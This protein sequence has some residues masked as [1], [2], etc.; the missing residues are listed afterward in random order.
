MPL[1]TTTIGSYPKPDFVPIPDWFQA[2]SG[3]D[4][5]NPTKSYLAALA[6]MGQE[7]EALFS[8]GVQQ[9]IDDQLEA[10]IDIP[11][12]GEIR[13]ENYIHYHCRHLEGI[14]FERLTEKALRAGAYSAELPT[15]TGPVKARAPFLP[16]DWKSAQACSDRPVKV[17]LPGPMTIVD[18]T[19]NTYYD[20]EEK[21][22]ADLADAINAEV[23]ALAEAGCTWIQVDEPVFARKAE[24]ALAYG[25]E[26][27]NRCFHAV[28]K[29][30]TRVM[31]MCCGY[32]D[33]LDRDDYPKADPES[34]F[35]LAEAVDRAGI[36]A[37]SLED[38]HRP[39]DLTL[40]ERFPSITVILGVVTIAKS[41][42]ETVEEIRAR[43]KAA[44]GHIDAERLIAAPDC[45]LGMLGRDLARAKLKNLC[46][47]ARLV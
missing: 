33:C 28:P 1:L 10:G 43:L 36:D 4:T 32:P 20:D 44:L 18:T 14:D 8:R 24:I 19:A 15:I 45:G 6:K 3:P 29:G 25:V 21:L 30:V 34:Y 9:V 37:V 42:I 23:R 41:R 5:S 11:T 38:A 35:R 46:Q 39:N 22:G 40:L 26:H 47:A 17:T 7:A 2:S 12:D 13:R 31:H 16:Q 27:L